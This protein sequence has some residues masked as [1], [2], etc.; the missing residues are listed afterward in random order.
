MEGK[1]TLLVEAD[2]RRKTLR[3]YVDEEPEVA[4]VDLLLGKHDTTKTNLY[5]EELGVEVIS[6]S[7]GGRNET[8]RICSRRNGS[9]SSSRSS[10]AS[11]TI[12]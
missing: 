5:N 9:A 6:G 2:I 1:R 4:L 3:A 11:S 8:R 12:S 7:D 10:A